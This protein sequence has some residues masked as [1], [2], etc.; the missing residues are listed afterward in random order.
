MPLGGGGAGNIAGGA[1][2]AGTGT[3]INYVGDHAY[4]NNYN[5]AQASGT[6]NAL[7]FST[8]NE[9]IVGTISAGQDNKPGSEHEFRLKINGQV[10]FE[11]KNDNGTQVT[12][13]S[14]FTAPL[15][16]LLPSN[17]HIQVEIDVNA[18][19]PVSVIF[20]GEVYN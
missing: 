19:T 6:F 11:C 15:N 4:G 7:D 12:A 17:S 10:V 3:G 18:T 14:P 8:G 20:V 2:P 5:S 1:N 13:Y 16:V 9:Y